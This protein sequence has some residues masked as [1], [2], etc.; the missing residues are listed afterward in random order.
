MLHDFKRLAKII[1]LRLYTRE[2]SRA[3]QPNAY[4]ISQLIYLVKASLLLNMHFHG[5][6]EPSMK[7]YL[8]TFLLCFIAFLT[9]EWWVRLP[10]K[11]SVFQ[12]IGQMSY[13][14]QIVCNTA[15]QCIALRYSAHCT[16]HTAH[17]GTKRWNNSSFEM[18]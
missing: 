12:R 15:T 7:F 14:T 1:A 13:V 17:T 11:Y 5:K 8:T 18:F 9:W 6:W 4:I 2:R 3:L 10:N 16:L